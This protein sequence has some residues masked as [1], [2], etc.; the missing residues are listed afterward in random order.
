MLSSS[1]NVVVLFASQ[2]NAYRLFKQ[3]NISNI[4]KGTNRKFLWIGSDAWAR[5][6]N[7]VHKY[8]ESLAGLFGIAPYTGF[9]DGF[10]NYFSQLTP[11]TNK[12]NPW[13]EEFYAAYRGCILNSSCIPYVPITSLPKYKQGKFIPL[14]ID[15][16]YSAAHALQDFVNANCDKPF[17]WDRSSMTC[18]GGKRELTGPVLLEYLRNVSFVSPTGR[19][20]NF[21]DKGSTEFQYEILNFQRVNNSVM[22]L[23]LLVHGMVPNNQIRDSLFILNYSLVSQRVERFL[24]VVSLIVNFVS[25]GVIIL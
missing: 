11:L 16:V 6:I 7:V 20:I 14:V 21:N 8:K 23:S 12:R 3:I 22:I 2:Y 25:I 18:N 1:A 9:S 15:A 4:L 13:F 17:T 5:S 19:K 24:K 10:M